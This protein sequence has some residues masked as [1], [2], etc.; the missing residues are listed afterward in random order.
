MSPFQNTTETDAVKPP[1]PPENDDQIL[2][3]STLVGPNFR[4]GYSRSYLPQNTGTA[5]N[6]VPG[7]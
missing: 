6:V 7:I 2:K 1:K 4:K 5:R 3:V